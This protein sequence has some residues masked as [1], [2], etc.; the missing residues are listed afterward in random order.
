MMTI[1]AQENV[2]TRVCVACRER[3]VWFDDDAELMQHVFPVTFPTFSSGGFKF[4]D[5]KFK[6]QSFAIP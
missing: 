3:D 1:A 6:V 2:E 5:S 4:Q